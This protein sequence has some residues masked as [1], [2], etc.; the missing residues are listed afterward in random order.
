MVHRIAPP[1]E[2][3]GLTW[4]RAL[5]SGGFAD[6]HLYRQSLPA[7]DVAVKVCLLYTSPSPRDRG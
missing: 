2:I 7:R 3:E 4:V 5:G 1:P 6:V